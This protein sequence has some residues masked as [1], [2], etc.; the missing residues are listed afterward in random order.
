MYKRPPPRPRR[1]SGVSLFRTSSL[2]AHDS[3]PA[4]LPIN[5]LLASHQAASVSDASSVS[6][7]H[8]DDADGRFRGLSVSQAGPT[9]AD[10]TLLDS[11][12][13]FRRL[14]DQ[15]MH[16]RGAFHMKGLVEDMHACVARILCRARR[17][18]SHRLSPPATLVSGCSQGDRASHRPLTAGTSPR[19]GA[20]LA[21]S[22][23]R[24][25]GMT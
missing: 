7:S 15:V 20:W 6:S 23:V 2:H 13:Q 19:L 11:L 14:E 18:P 21:A 17:R 22:S 1:S 4:R 25:R 10:A 8:T 3:P 5:P 9:S 24:P 16:V 12:A